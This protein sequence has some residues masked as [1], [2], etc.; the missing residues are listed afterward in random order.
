MSKLNPKY[1]GPFPIITKIGQVAYRL[2]LSEDSHIHP[3]FHVSLLK[4]SVGTQEVSPSLQADS[5][6]LEPEDIV[7]KRVIYKQGAPLI[8]VLVKWQDGAV[9]DSTWE[10]LP[11][12]LKQFPR[13]ANLLSIS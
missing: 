1:Y 7:D 6:T 4:K 9:D 13:S 5:K 8:Q 2:Q 3:V 10:Y 12:L 11:D